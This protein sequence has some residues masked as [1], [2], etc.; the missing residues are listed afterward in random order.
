MAQSALAAA[1]MRFPTEAE[2]EYAC[3][4]STA[5]AFNNGSDD[6]A[7]AGDVAWFGAN[8]GTQTRPVGS[9]APNSLGFHDM[10]GNVWEWVG[11]WYGSTYY[12]A[13]PS[14]NPPGPASGSL[15]LLRGGAFDSLTNGLRSSFRFARVAS[16]VD[17]SVGVRVARDP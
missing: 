16:L 3:R 4:A 9:K 1:G 17:R 7:A 12:S 10:H 13:S 2:W 8:S 14:S 11:D 5:T 6:D 15:R